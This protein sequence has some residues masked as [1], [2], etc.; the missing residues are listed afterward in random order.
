MRRIA[1]YVALGS[2][3]VAAVV[4]A[5][6]VSGKGT[7]S[8]DTVRP[9]PALPQTVLVAPSLRISD[10]AGRPA[11]VHF[12]AS[13]CGP[14]TKEAPEL[15]RLAQQ[16]HGRAR[17]VGV[18]WSDSRSNASAFI[19]KHGWTFPILEDDAGRTGT[20]WGIDGLPTTFLLDRRGRIVK[21]LTGPQTA[22]GLL[23]ELPS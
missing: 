13:W 16:L 5:E 10:L 14:C 12:W 15:E 18:D 4:I 22:A 9:A 21:R 23:A 11:I 20:P 2:A 7:P 3:I 1:R 6:V 19:H 17:L 8:V